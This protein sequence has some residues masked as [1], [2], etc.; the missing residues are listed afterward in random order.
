M[1]NPDPDDVRLVALEI[2]D[3]DDKFC[4]AM[5]KAVKDG[6]ENVPMIG[7]D[8]KPGTQHPRRIEPRPAPP[9]QRSGL[10]DV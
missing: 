7:V 3:Q 6:L 10:G 5:L 1:N 9:P 2:V 8:T 4:Q